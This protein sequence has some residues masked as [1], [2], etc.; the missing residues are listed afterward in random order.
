M[1]IPPLPG[2][3]DLDLM[4]DVYTHSSLRHPNAPQNQ[5]Y[6][7]TGRLGELGSKVLDLAV[8]YHF[9]SERPFLDPET[10]KVTFY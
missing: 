5:Y 7:D 2:I 4:L 3:D 8:T 6:G 9:Y 10:R 1:T